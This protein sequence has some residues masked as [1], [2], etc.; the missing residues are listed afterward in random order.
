MI[1]EKCIACGKSNFRHLYT[2]EN[3]PFRSLDQLNYYRCM[4]CGLV[5][6]YPMPS[7]ED[8]DEYYQ[9]LERNPKKIAIDRKISKAKKWY[10][11]DLNYMEHILGKTGKILDIGCSYGAFLKQ[12]EDKRWEAIGLEISAPKC[13]YVREELGLEVLN[14]DANSI[15]VDQSE[16]TG[17]F[18]V[19]AAAHLIEHLLDPGAFLIKIGKLLRKNGII[20]IRVPNWNSFSRK[21]GGVSTSFIPMHLWYF[22]P[23][24]LS[25]LLCRYGYKAFLVRTRE[26]PGYFSNPVLD[27]ATCLIKRFGLNNAAKD[28]TG[29]K[30]EGDG[31][32][33]HHQLRSSS[34][35]QRI[36]DL[37]SIV[38]DVL[39][40]LLNLLYAI[41][42]GN[43]LVIFARK[44]NEWSS[45][46]NET[47]ANPI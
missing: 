12:A 14:I 37:T 24:V 38:S 16:L 17:S 20:Y 46:R 43:E 21:I 11:H 30:L 34:T 6:C 47:V 13:K 31:I 10:I 4:R 27:S 28:F 25:L 15:D 23:K 32:E 5:F 18:D 33:K 42:L 19:V 22:S 35:Y 41:G 7:S 45:T 26:S 40:P 29:I 9:R 3:S 36:V 1:H 39:S 8:L 44:I 2:S